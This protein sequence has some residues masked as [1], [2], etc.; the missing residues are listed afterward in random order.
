VLRAKQS[1]AACGRSEVQDQI[2]GSA[3]FQLVVKG[4][5]RYFLKK[6]KSFQEQVY[7]LIINIFS[8]NRSRYSQTRRATVD[9]INGFGAKDMKIFG[10]EASHNACSALAR[11][12][13][14]EGYE[15]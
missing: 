2:K 1:V 10:R 14:Y 13:G 11:P 15:F 4:T 7:Y 5:I 8:F 9:D 6:L 3:L 12:F